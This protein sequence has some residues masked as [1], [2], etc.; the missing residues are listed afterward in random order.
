M[1]EDLFLLLL[2]RAMHH[3]RA[4]AVV[5][6]R[7]PRGRRRVPQAG[8]VVM[9]AHHFECIPLVIAACEG[10]VRPPAAVA[11]A[12]RTLNHAIIR[13][14]CARFKWDSSGT[15]LHGSNTSERSW[16]SAGSGRVGEVGGTDGRGPWA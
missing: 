11:A 7:K 8:A 14:L 3:P 6:T 10:V 16:T 4:V 13:E 5:I 1:V 9:V 15:E 2:R 12:T